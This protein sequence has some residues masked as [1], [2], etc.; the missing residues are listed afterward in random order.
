MTD[1]YHDIYPVKEIAIKNCSTWPEDLLGF[2]ESQVDILKAWANPNSYTASVKLAEAYDQVIYQL[3]DIIGKYYLRGY[4]CTRLTDQEIKMI[5]EQGMYLP[6]KETLESRIRQLVANEQL[7]VAQAQLL[8]NDNEANDVNR[9]GR[10]WF[11]FFEPRLASEHGIGRFFRSWGGEALYN[12][13]EENENTGTVLRNIGNP[14][15]IETLLPISGFKGHSLAMKF[16]KEFMAFKSIARETLNDYEGDITVPLAPE[17][18]LAIHQFP[19]Q[20]FNELS[21]CLDWFEPLQ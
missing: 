5:E 13:H 9:K 19:G 21:G 1:K 10:L 16:T 8:L 14:C 18:I 12:A 4:H 20:R 17:H 15:I 6:S 7:T 2:Y 3:P 11:T